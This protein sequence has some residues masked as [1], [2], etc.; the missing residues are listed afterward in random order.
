M[1]PSWPW[2]LAMLATGAGCNAFAEQ[3]PRGVPEP[4]A[5]TCVDRERARVNVE[6]TPLVGPLPVPNDR[7]LAPLDPADRTS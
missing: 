4:G 1:R 6:S 2:A 7:Q 3:L 5:E